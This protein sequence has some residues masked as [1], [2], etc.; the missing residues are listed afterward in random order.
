MSNARQY[1]GLARKAA[2]LV[3]GEENSGCA[4]AAGKG[5]LLLLAQDASDNAE[6]RAKGFQYGHRAPLM[7]L[8]WTK[9]ELSR[10]MGKPGCSML[11]FTDLPMSAQ[12]SAAMAEEDPL[13]QETASLLEARKQ[14]AIRRK[15]APR[16]HGPI[17]N[18]GTKHGN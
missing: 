18:G 3:V 16:K 5:K 9:E 8:P 2:L 7:R 11:C 6:K 1:L 14:K 4:M 13:W 10:L 17:G 15:A 12:F